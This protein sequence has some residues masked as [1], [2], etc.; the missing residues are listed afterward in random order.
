MKDHTA[1]LVAG[2]AF[3][4]EGK[5]AT[6][7]FLVRDKSAGLVVR[8][9]GGAQAA[10]NVVCHQGHHTFAQ[11][12]AGT[13]VPGVRTHL[14]RFMVV[15]PG[16]MLNEEQ[17]LRLIGITDAFARTTVEDQAIVVTP[18]HRAVN[19]LLEW[20][21]GPLQHGT[22]GM[23]I[24]QA[25]HDFILHGSK[26]LMVKDLVH[27]DLVREKLEFHR[28]L[29]QQALKNL[30]MAPTKH[31]PHLQD[32]WQVVFGAREPVFDLLV[33]RYKEWVSKVQIVD[34]CFLGFLLDQYHTVVFE[35][36]QG[37]LLDEKHGFI[38]H[39]TW[40]NTTFENAETLLM[41]GNYQGQ[42]VRVGCLRSYYTRHGAGPFAS[43]ASTLHPAF[44]E[45]HNGSDGAQGAFRVGYF[46]VVY[47][48]Q[49][50]RIVGG[51]DFLSMSHLD[52]LRLLDEWKVAVEHQ[53]GSHRV[54]RY[55]QVSTDPREYVALLEEYLDTRVK[56]VGFGARSTQRTWRE[57]KWRPLSAQAA[58]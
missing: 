17:D 35:G 1:Y 32:E 24:G 7:D 15:N 51:V 13:F 27:E 47:A 34:A 38:P 25:R 29:A 22:C 16:A 39:N 46:D 14:S 19:R 50:L 9:N 41:E 8:Y 55:E 21:R 45:P 33:A 12:G 23:G 56:I 18:Y 36:A 5:G 52:R 28:E 31:T 58:Y 26:V 30:E 49:A 53:A 3:G 42:Q 20:R 4:D 10:H 40:T 11:F 37:V 43:E 6:V 54:S 2:L 44:P 57:S 48:R